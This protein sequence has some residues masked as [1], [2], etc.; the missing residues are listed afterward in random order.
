MAVAGWTESLPATPPGGPLFRHREKSTPTDGT[1][2][3][4]SGGLHGQPFASSCGRMLTELLLQNYRSVEFARPP[5]PKTRLF[6]ESVQ[7]KGPNFE[8]AVSKVRRYARSIR[9]R[10]GPVE[11]NSYHAMFGTQRML[12]HNEPDSSKQPLNFRNPSAERRKSKPCKSSSSTRPSYPALP[13]P[14]RQRVPCPG[15]QTARATLLKQQHW[16]N[17]DLLPIQPVHFS[18]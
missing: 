1:R 9:R 11:L 7:Q 3:I 16:Q 17:L 12:T 2:I 8:G 6:Y 14:D 18:R 15:Q 13:C 4:V 5:A 10:A